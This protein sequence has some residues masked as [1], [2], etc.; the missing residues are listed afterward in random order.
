[1]TR[2]FATPETHL[3]YDAGAG[4]VRATIATF[5]T[6]PAS[7][8]GSKAR[9]TSKDSTSIEIKAIGYSR[10]IGG[11]ELDRRLRD[12]LIDKF[13]SR[14][15]KDVRSDARGMAKLWKE[16]GRVKG[17]LSANSEAVAIVR[18]TCFTVI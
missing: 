9:S 6:V 5:S 14:S 2:T 4:S 18:W 13:N 15:Q 3:I 10:Q 17:V 1:M 12:I 7:D 8:N 11:D 16:A